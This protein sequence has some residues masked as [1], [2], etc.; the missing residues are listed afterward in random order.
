MNT[1]KK[2]K[3]MIF[4]YISNIIFYKWKLQYYILS[5]NYNLH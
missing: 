2:N 4:M 5:Y 1:H 3:E